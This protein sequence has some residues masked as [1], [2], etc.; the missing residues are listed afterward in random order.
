LH[1]VLQRLAT[2]RLTASRKRREG[3]DGARLREA[4]RAELGPLLGTVEPVAD[5]KTWSETKRETLGPLS[6]ERLTLELS[7]PGGVVPLPMLIV[8][9]SKSSAEASPPV[10]VAISQ[11]GKEALLKQ[12]AEPLGACLARGAVVVLP[13]LRNTGETLPAGE[14]RGRQSGAT[15]RSSS[16]LMLGETMLGRR[17]RD[18]RT[19]LAYLRG[20]DDLRTSPITLYGD[21]LVPGRSTTVSLPTFHAK[22]LDVEQPAPCEPMPAAACLLTALWEDS[23]QTVVAAGGLTSYQSV[24]DGPYFHVPHDAVVPGQLAHADVDDLV[25]AQS[26]RVN[27]IDQRNALNEESGEEAPEDALDY[28][29]QQATSRLPLK[30]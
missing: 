25:K 28:A 7:E 21:G 29:L 9:D 14:G 1:L 6:V 24:L 27:L 12:R 11:S 18:L 30:Q 17:V 8:R 16:E 15:S 4:L 5:V 20:R 26:A 23:I 2:E 10:V 13:D 3:L 19:I 22:P